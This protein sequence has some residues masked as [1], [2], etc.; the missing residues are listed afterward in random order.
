MSIRFLALGIENEFDVLA[1][2]Q[3]ARDIAAIC[4]FA[5]QDQA[6]ISTAV[7][8]LARNVYN[9]VGKGRIEYSIEGSTAPQLLK[10]VIED[11][12]PGIPHIK[13]VLS[14]GYQSPTGMGLGVIG[15]KRLMDRFDITTDSS[16]TTI[17][18]RKFLPATA[19]LL[20][21]VMVGSSISGLAELAPNISLSEVQHQNRELLR[22]LDELNARQKEL[23]SLTQELEDTN[24]GVVALYAELDEK[25]SHLRRA[26]ELKSRFLS[27]MSH[28]FRTP[29]NSIRALAKLLLDKMD[30]ELTTEQEVQVQYILKG[31][32]SLSDLVNDL[33]DIAK[34]EAGK[35]EIKP[36]TFYVSEMISA[37]R[38][39][40][41][42]L[43]VSNKLALN[44]IYPEEDIEL[45]QDEPKISQILRNFISNSLKFT[46]AGSIDVSVS[47]AKDQCVTFA[48]KDTGLGISEEHLELIFEEFSQV[49]NRLQ[50]GVKGTGLGLPLCKNLA[51]L[52]KGKVSVESTLGLGSTFSV[53]IPAHFKVI[54][55]VEESMPVVTIADNRLPVMIIEDE[56]YE[57]LLYERY[58]ADSEFKVVP[59]RSLRE[60]NALWGHVKPA[61][62][63]LDILLKGEDSWR[64]LSDMKQD[65]Q[66]KHVPV[67]I[68]SSVEDER[69]GLALG[70]DAYFHKPLLKTDL[71]ASLR[72][73]LHLQQS[74]TMEALVSAKTSA[75]DAQHMTSTSD[76]TK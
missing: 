34:I 52:L 4:G 42:P 33:L 65:D 9:Y 25:A 20:T 30:G 8:E 14:G 32:V 17:T 75:I 71:L 6:R 26:D 68:A 55:P 43:L 59:A 1:A 67:I 16:G 22:T 50:K 53:T 41:K 31:A 11:K 2:R 44:F 63:L 35:T 37:L 18:L 54:T 39:M 73:L 28:E 24:R 74:D 15:A 72:E 12:G 49:E 27:N 21:P 56:A 3:R 45:F 36:T 5:L 47:I 40:L 70:A 23:L 38:G 46:E 51:T 64:W 29:L 60:A 66:R 58:L 57:Q 61:A 48:V 62:V 10:I 76:T 7:S 69:K 13:E 19:P